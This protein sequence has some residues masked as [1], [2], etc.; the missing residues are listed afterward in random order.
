MGELHSLTL[1][2]DRAELARL[3]TWIDELAGQ[4]ELSPQAKYAVQLCLEE[5]IVNII[6]YAFEP[7]TENEVKINVC[8][9]GRTVCAEIT[10]HGRPFD[11]LTQEVRQRPA[12]LASAHIGGLGITLMR[13]FA[14][15][16]GYQRADGMNR[17]TL[18]FAT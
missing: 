10:D 12:D 5:A 18:S 7:G 9:D 16:I 2:N 4:L 14:A 11:P 3:M 6:S 1:R 8:R 15:T 17:L 13:N